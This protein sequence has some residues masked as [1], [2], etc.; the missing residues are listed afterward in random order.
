MKGLPKCAAQ[1]NQSNSPSFKRPRLNKK[2]PTKQPHPAPRTLTSS[3]LDIYGHDEPLP[4]TQQ[5]YQPSR[6]PVTSGS[7]SVS[8]R[9]ETGNKAVT[10]RKDNGTESVIKN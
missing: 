6:Q 8:N 5:G 3:Y 2:F 7:K 4:L 10:N 9:K 1:P